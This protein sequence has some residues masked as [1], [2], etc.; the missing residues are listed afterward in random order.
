MNNKIEN[1]FKAVRKLFPVTGNGRGITYLNSASTG[2]LS[3]PVKEK[4]DAYYQ[5]TQYLDKNSD[6]AAFANLDKIRKFGARLIGARA[7]EVGYGFHT[8]YGLNIA[9]FGLPLKMGDEVLLSDIEFPSNVYPWLGLRERGIN[10]KFIKSINRFFDIDNLKKAIGKKSK[11]LS[12]SFVQFF[13]GYKNDLKTIGKICKDYGLYFVVDGIQGCGVETLNVHNCMVDIF[14]SGA[15]KWL[16]SPLGTGFFYIRKDLQ[17]ELRTP[18]TSWLSVDWKLNFTDLFHYDLPYFDSARR[19][20]M[21]TYPY[22]HVHAMAAALEIIDSLGVKNIQKHNHQLLDILIEYL[23]TS[24]HYRI[25][26]N[27]E[28]KHRSSI[29]SFTS[30]DV[31][32][33]HQEL[34]KNKI[35]CVLREGAV[36]VSV[37]L[38]NNEKDIKRLI[39]VLKKFE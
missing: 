15:Q 33:V 30:D 9:A 22:A 2:P 20:E 4:L 3:N 27:L 28:N 1:K 8:G 24:S 18:F 7:D 35:I 21:G 39:S 11:V 37:H 29:L 36:R 17:K 25:V 5:S 14:S 32:I 23:K 19:F 13:N 34:L 31:R 10:V 38:Y 6:Y 16:L 26:S 12:L